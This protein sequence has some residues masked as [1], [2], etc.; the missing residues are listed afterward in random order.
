MKRQK[1]MEISACCQDVVESARPSPVEQ[2]FSAC[3]DHVHPSTSL[4]VRCGGTELLAGVGTVV[5]LSELTSFHHPPDFD[6]IV[7][8]FARGQE[9]GPELVA[10]LQYCRMLLKPGG[11]LAL[12]LPRDIGQNWYHSLFAHFPFARAVGR[13]CP[14]VALMVQAGFIDIRK[15]VR[16]G[17]GRVISGARPGKGF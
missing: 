17:L 1:D 13:E 11:R 14:R 5:A 3:L 4:Q 6:L 15:Q 8:T 9:P 10:A 7:C 2:L 16:P 12:L